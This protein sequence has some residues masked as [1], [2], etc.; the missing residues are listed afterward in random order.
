MYMTIPQQQEKNWF[1]RGRTP[2]KKQ[3]EPMPNAPQD[4]YQYM[5]ILSM[6]SRPDTDFAIWRTFVTIGKR[7]TET[8]SRLTPRWCET[9]K[10]LNPNTVVTNLLNGAVMVGSGLVSGA[11]GL[12]EA[13]GLKEKGIKNSATGK[14]L[15][16]WFHSKF[17]GFEKKIKG[18]IGNMMGRA[19]TR[20]E[21][22]QARLFEEM[23][24]NEL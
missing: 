21:R 15:S 4:N 22:L 18:G 13:A 16:E 1:Y 2:Q 10:V 7:C 14:R 8:E 23:E 9:P 11:T 24:A 5:K 6:R 3:Y 12:A 19:S 17:K 20:Y